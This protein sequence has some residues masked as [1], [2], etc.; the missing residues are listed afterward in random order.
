[1]P[2]PPRP[3][4]LAYVLRLIWVAGQWQISLQ[5]VRTEEKLL[6]EDLAALL[7]YLE[8]LRLDELPRDDLPREGG[9]R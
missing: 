2:S 5:N 1:M 3:T 8:H 6:F 4:R 7:R 9:L